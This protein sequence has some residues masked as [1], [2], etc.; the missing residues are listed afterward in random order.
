MLLEQ[1][2]NQK[3]EIFLGIH[4]VGIQKNSKNC[5]FRFLTQTG[6]RS[7]IFQFIK[8]KFEPTDDSYVTLNFS[9]Y[10]GHM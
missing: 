8:R 6:S 1:L 4:G 10:L 2:E 9:A 3:W 7:R 5:F